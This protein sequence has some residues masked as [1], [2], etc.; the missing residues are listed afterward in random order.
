[1][2]RTLRTFAVIL[3]LIS[4]R[5]PLVMLLGEGDQFSVDLPAAELQQLMG[6]HIQYQLRLQR[7]GVAIAGGGFS[8]SE[9]GLIGLTLLRTSSLEEAQRIANADPAVQAKRFKATVREWWVPAGRL[10]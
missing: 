1:M 7:D 8:Q 2:L 9:D 3:V 5:Q 6:D 10:D 4:A